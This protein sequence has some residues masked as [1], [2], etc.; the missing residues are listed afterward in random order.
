MSFAV[1]LHVIVREELF[2]LETVYIGPY[3][4][5]FKRIR[6]GGIDVTED[7]IDEQEAQLEAARKLGATK[8]DLKITKMI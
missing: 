2:E 7:N 3:E 8:N 4:P 5:S 6:P 1:C